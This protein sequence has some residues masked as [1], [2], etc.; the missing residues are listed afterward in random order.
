[1]KVN[2]KGV[3]A[4]ILG[5]G[6][7]S[8]LYPLTETRSKPAVPIGGKYRLVDIPISNCINSDIFKIFVLTQFNSAS[9]N[10]H[11][12][13][14]FNFSIFSQSFVDILAAEQTPDNPTW[15]QGTADAVRQCMSHFLKHDFEY[16][17]ILSGDQLYQ[18][19]FNE[20]LDAHIAADAAISI[21]T[22][23]VNAKDAPEFGILKTNNESCI[24]AF[25]E[26][27]NASLLPEWESEV[28][29]QMQAQ[30]KK[31]L[32]SMGIY[33]FN[34]QLLEDLMS[35]PDTK[36]FGKE[37]IP[38][39]VGKHKILSYQYEGYWTDIG[40]I[41]SF[42]EANIGLTADI[43][44]FNLFDN[45]NKIFTRPRLLPPSK[46]RNSNINQSLISEGC[47]I[48]A[49]EIKSSVIGIRSRIGDGTVIQHSYVMGNDFY[50]DLDEMNQ[51]TINNKIHIGI[52]ENCFIKNVLVDKNVRIGN[53]VYIN[54]GKHLENFTN[55]LYSIKDGI[56]VIK[57]GVVLP[58]NFRID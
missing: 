41:E 29:E 54:G 26:K 30:G 45:D 21:A 46:F 51:D 42:F 33:I 36:D 40:N 9:L 12:K 19:D 31:Y 2:K 49:Q 53:N 13:N 23:P 3:V 11:I 22:L 1:M 16:A 32:A 50:Q 34:R 35:D 6:Q 39:A 18:M 47:I 25:I 8:R 24:E 20:M 7:G 15:F 56:V 17:L 52:G 28:S 43:P 10:A 48:N 38:Q 37:I 4:I 44:E 27:P 55:E 58:D 57:K 5:G 14:T